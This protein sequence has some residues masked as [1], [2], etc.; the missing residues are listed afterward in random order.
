MVI[1]CMNGLDHQNVVPQTKDFSLALYWIVHHDKVSLV[2]SVFCGFE[3]DM[4]PK[5]RFEMPT[6]HN[7]TRTVDIMSLEMSDRMEKNI[8]HY[9]ANKPG[10]DIDKDE[11]RPTDT[12]A[13]PSST[14]SSPCSPQRD[15]TPD[16][17][18][19][20]DD[21]D[22][23]DD[24][25][26]DASVPVQRSGSG[27]GSDS[28]INGNNRICDDSSGRTGEKDHDNCG[29]GSKCRV[30][31]NDEQ[32]LT[33]QYERFHFL[34]YD[35]HLHLE[36]FNDGGRN[37][38]RI[39]DTRD[40]LHSDFNTD[41]VR[42]VIHIDFN[43]DE[44][45][46]GI[47]LGAQYI[48]QK[49]EDR[50][51]GVGDEYGQVILDLAREIS[52]YVL[53]HMERD[54]ERTAIKEMMR[55]NKS[56][57]VH[58]GDIQRGACAHLSMLFKIIC[59]YYFHN[60]RQYARSRIMCRLVRGA[61]F[62]SDKGRYEAHAWNIIYNRYDGQE[63]LIDCMNHPNRVLSIHHPEARPY[64]ID[65]R[66][67][68][69][70]LRKLTQ[71][72]A[73]NY[74]HVCFHRL[75]LLQ[76]QCKGS[77][78]A[79]MN[80]RELALKIFAPEDIMPAARELELMIYLTHENIIRPEFVLPIEHRARILT[81]RRQYTLGCVELRLSPCQIIHIFQ[82]VARAVAH[83]HDRQM[84][85]FHIRPENIVFNMVDDGTISHV[86]LI[87][88]GAARFFDEISAETK[89][90]LIPCEPY[91]PPEMEVGM[92]SIAPDRV[93]SFSFG[94]SLAK[95]WAANQQNSERQTP[96]ELY[97]L[98][99]RCM[100]HDASERPPFSVIVQQLEQIEK[101]VKVSEDPS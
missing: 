89:E 12:V 46:K 5:R 26:N 37:G 4:F 7:A 101:I 3:Q 58:L 39:G 64:C 59:D 23:V 90:A 14:L 81:A 78:D 13:S 31:T 98:L 41:D 75:H 18:D 82:H 91:A 77:F 16:D 17:G 9:C 2:H 32:Q 69:C 50:L 79:R 61:F 72:G 24:D 86:Q 97:S 71:K 43:T 25:D 38:S 83:M 22:S 53:Q 11:D 65:R 51:T 20:D 49:F 6:S 15:N 34:D 62:N 33:Q 30:K 73:S 96:Y 47:V 1:G 74:D 45:L 56:K 67:H 60:R 10:W 27:S 55:T 44:K 63:Y 28:G 54:A 94:V 52:S 84:Y 68:R 92:G 21:G 100:R 40:V 57:V 93:D 76:E 87:D 48:F 36:E 85:H 95:V 42:E 88:L 19:D 70:L 29:F 66:S 80:R 8:R 35:Q 99:A